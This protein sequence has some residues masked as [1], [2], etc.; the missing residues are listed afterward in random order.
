[1]EPIEERSIARGVEYVTEPDVVREWQLLNLVIDASHS[2]TSLWEFRILMQTHVRKMFPHHYAVCGIGQVQEQRVLRVINIDFPES[3][4]RVLIQPDQS[5]RHELLDSWLARKEP[6]LTRLDETEGAASRPWFDSARKYRLETVAQYGMIESNGQTFSFFS[7]AQLSS[8][9][10]QDH[11]RLLRAL[12]P[13]LHT[14]LAR[15]LSASYH[16]S[17]RNGR[18]NSPSI[19]PATA[20][21]MEAM[22]SKRAALTQREHEILSWIRKGKTNWEIAQILDLSEHTV[23]NH[24][25]NILRKLG[26]TNRAQAVGTNLA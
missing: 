17:L 21:P 15:G 9:A 7:F 8:R 23:K 18:S 16:H 10:I 2:V 20:P 4:L 22:G 3:L 26:V 11:G 24:I 6:T 19:R 13:Q 14:A 25:R 12:V 1:M 5:L